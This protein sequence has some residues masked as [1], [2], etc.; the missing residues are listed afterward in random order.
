MGLAEEIKCNWNLDLAD[1]MQ[2]ISS[3]RATYPA[4][5]LKTET[6]FGVAVSYDGELVREDFSNAKIYCENV[7]V[8]GVITQMLV[9]S[10]KKKI[11]DPSFLNLCVDFINPGEN[12]EF[13]SIL[14][15]S[16][17]LWWKS[18]KELLGN[19]SVDD[20]IYD[21]IG[22][23]SVLKYYAELGHTPTWNGPTQASYDIE[24]SDCFV[25][26]KSS[27]NR[28]KKEVTINSIHQLSPRDKT[29]YLVFCTFEPVESN[30]ISIET[31]VEDLKSMGYNVSKINEHLEK[32]GFGVGKSA[33]RKKFLLHSMIRYIV[34]ESF[35][36]ITEQSFINGVLPAGITDISYTV[37][38]SGL[39]ST[40]LFVV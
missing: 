23:L 25:E 11:I 13:R 26:V 38:L 15:G 37:D 35:P 40:N 18:W 8:N 30:G 5:T 14:V 12:G 28:S 39:S 2:E 21:V 24:M 32:K 31:V 3:L 27:I 33:R 1:R 17:V 6:G 19:V 22:E 16:P 10:S 36:K 20:R 29:L 9:L 7:N 34:D 4:W